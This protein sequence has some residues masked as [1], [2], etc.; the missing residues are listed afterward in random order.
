MPICFLTSLTTALRFL[1]AADSCLTELESGL[2]VSRSE[3]ELLVVTVVFS[4]SSAWTGDG[5][6][7]AEITA[8]HTDTAAVYFTKLPLTL[9]MNCL[10]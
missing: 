2:V 4:T 7:I 3:I 8:K 6:L 9:K 1:V 10:L 5:T